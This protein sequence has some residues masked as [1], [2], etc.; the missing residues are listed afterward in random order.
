[1]NKVKI[2][3]IITLTV[4][5]VSILMGGIIP[6]IITMFYA[7]N[8]GAI[9]IIGGA[10]GPT[11][12][13]LTARLMG[14]LPYCL[15]WVGTGLLLLSLVYLIFSKTAVTHCSKKTFALAVGIAA[16]CAVGL[17]SGMIWLIISFWSAR[18]EHPIQFPANTALMGICLAAFVVLLV[19]YIKTRKK[20]W[21]A[22]GN[23]IKLRYC[24]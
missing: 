5:A 6:Y 14:G 13:Y 19:L 17:Y 1:M 16:A 2:Y 7:E 9:G 15:L 10:D 12:V 23:V 3:S 11:A 4:G 22:K 21:S 20:K 24:E 18:G 8:Y